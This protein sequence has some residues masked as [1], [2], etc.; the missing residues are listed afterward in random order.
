M[1]MGVQRI[2]GAVLIIM[3]AVFTIVLEGDATFL[4]A[5]CLPFGLSA[6]FVDPEKLAK[7]YY[8]EETR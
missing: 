7:K 2:M 8:G 3:G 6:I 5:F 1:E 4:R